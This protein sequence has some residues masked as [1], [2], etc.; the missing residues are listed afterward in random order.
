MNGYRTNG[1]R[2]VTNEII[3]RL[4]CGTIPWRQTWKSGLPTNAV[5]H[6]PYRGINV[7]LLSQHEYQSNLWLTYNQARQLDGYVKR[8]ERGR[9]IVFW[10]ITETV[11]EET[12]EV[13]TIPLLRTYTVFNVDQTTVEVDAETRAF[14]PI[15]EAQGIIDGYQDKPAV[16]PG[17]PAYHPTTDIVTMLSPTAFDSPDEYYSTMFHELSHS[18]GHQSR[19]GRN[20]SNHFG[21]D[22]Y[23]EEE[24]VSEMSASYL[25][26]MAGTEVF[27]KTIDNAAAYIKSWIQRFQ[28]ND[29]LIISLSSRAQ[30]SADWIL[31]K[32]QQ[33]E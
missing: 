4:R 7:W 3:D 15:T 6:R 27:S 25:S 23:A 26:A 13:R 33:A 20:I 8:G 11:D 14:D 9:K 19:L 2:K 31:G 28:D 12:D 29:R 22:P 5:S 21:S 16:A 10:K 1:Y 24:V 32:R 17:E 18:T 30:R